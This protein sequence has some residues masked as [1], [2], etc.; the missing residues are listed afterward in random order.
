MEESDDNLALKQEGGV[1]LCPEETSNPLQENISLSTPSENKD[2][3][4]DLEGI[5]LLD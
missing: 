3:T 5:F 4:V 1:R 2:L